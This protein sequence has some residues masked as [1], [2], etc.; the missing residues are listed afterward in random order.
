MRLFDEASHNCDAGHSVGNS[1]V[2]FVVA[3]KMPTRARL[4]L[5]AGRF[6]QA[7]EA[8]PWQKNRSSEPTMRTA[9][10][11]CGAVRIEARGEPVRV[12]LCHCTTCRKQ[13][14]AAFTANAIWR[15][16]DV[17]IRGDTRSWKDTTVSRHFCSSCGS[18]LFGASGGEIAIGFGA[19]DQAPTNLVP[20]YELWVGRR[21]KWLR[22]TTPTEEFPGHRT[23]VT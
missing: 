18:S 17:T 1:V 20:T 6:G 12:G 13:S 22:L 23:A 5:E 8:W 15:A 19:F 7:R 9:S 16:E 21:E 14:G 3:A 4:P 10:C 2:S 11:S